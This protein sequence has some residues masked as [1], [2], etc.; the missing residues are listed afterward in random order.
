[1]LQSKL[2]SQPRNKPAALS[3]SKTVKMLPSR[4]VPRFLSKYV[5]RLQKEH[6]AMSLSELKI[7]I[8]KMFRSKPVQMSQ[9]KTVKK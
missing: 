4:A 6:A 1:M 3:Q 9:Y 5:T 2:A 8:V 7:K